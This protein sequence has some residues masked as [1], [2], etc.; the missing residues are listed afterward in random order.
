MIIKY[1]PSE[2]QGPRSWIM[3]NTSSCC[4]SLL[5]EGTGWLM[6][7]LTDWAG[8]SHTHVHACTQAYTPTKTANAN[9]AAC[10]C[11][12]FKEGHVLS[13]RKKKH[14]THIHKNTVPEGTNY[15][16]IVAVGSI[17]RAPAEVWGGGISKGETGDKEERREASMAELQWSRWGGC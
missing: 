15:F 5:Q 9:Q 6:D 17:R 10:K 8:H 4:S 3:S 1:Y 12:L 2:P 14:D 11:I 13:A 7:W 16:H